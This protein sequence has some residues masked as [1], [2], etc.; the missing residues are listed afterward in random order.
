[1]H[2]LALSLSSLIITGVVTGPTQTATVGRAA[3]VVEHGPR[4]V[5]KIALTFDACPTSHEDDEYDTGVIEVL[6][7]E[8]VPATLFLSGR[9]VEKNKE[10]AKFLASQPRFEIANHSYWHSHLLEKDDERVLRE[11]TRTQA[12]IRNVTGKR[13]TYFRPP[14]GEVDGRVAG[15]AENAG[16]V[17]VQYDVA[18]GDPDPALP[19]ER[20]IR[21]VVAEAHGGSI[22]VFHMNKNG[23]RTDVVLPA[24]IRELRQKGYEL[25]TVG[26]LL[27]SGS[28]EKERARER[29]GG[30]AA[31][32][33]PAA[34]QSSVFH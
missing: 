7:R 12:I 27:K 25:V 18:S 5:K 1:M 28:A 14:F 22:V 8:N 13:P 6:E 17:T 21:A 31:R 9:W 3:P 24:V 20:I 33:V 29:K 19:A 15:I 30:A 4:S 2:L 11:L 16:L 23:V 34:R 10:A 26:D 32:P